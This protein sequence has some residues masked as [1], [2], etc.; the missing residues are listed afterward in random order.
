MH[1]TFHHQITDPA[2]RE[3]LWNL[4][5][6]GFRDVA[7]RAVYRLMLYR[8]EFDEEMRSSTTR[9]W[10]VWDDTTPV[11]LG[12]IATDL[13]SG[14]FWVN[15]RYLARR[16][17]EHFAAGRVHYNLFVVVAPE[18]RSGRAASILMRKGLAMEAREDVV[19]IFDVGDANQS[20]D[21]GG[22]AAFGAR[23]AGGAELL[24]IIE[25]QRYYGLHLG[26]PRADAAPELTRAR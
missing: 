20:D 24:E 7:D 19:L 8:S 21:F 10:V 1:V 6:R 4:Y 23:A 16:Y 17:P 2:M 15:P 18:Y 5:E 13:A 3:R 11:G 26:R 25:T 12:A 9:K 14:N 22:L